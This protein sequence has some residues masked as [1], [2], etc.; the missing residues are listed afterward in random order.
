MGPNYN[1]DKVIKESAALILSGRLEIGDLR[2][3]LTPHIN[4]EKELKLVMRQVDRIVM[5]EHLAIAERQKAKGLLLSGAL[6]L[7]VGLFLTIGSSMGFL[8]FKGAVI[9]A[10]G[11]ILGGLFVA[12]IGWSKLKR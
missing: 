1:R 9:V 10:Y 5:R 6:I 7:F 11:P 12:L 8:Q 2:Q 3:N 4:D